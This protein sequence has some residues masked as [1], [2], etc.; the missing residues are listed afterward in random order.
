MRSRAH[1]PIAILVLLLASA[2]PTLAG[3]ATPAATWTVGLKDVDQKLRAR[4]WEAAEKQAR[5]VAVQIIEGSGTGPGASYSLA[6]ISAFRAIAAAGLG[7]EDEADW[8]WASALNLFPDIA[9]TDLA[10]YGPPAAGLK[11][12]QLRFTETDS[13]A[14]D[15]PKVIEETKARQEDVQPPKI[16]RQVRPR[17]PEGLRS[18]RVAGKVVM[19]TIIGEDGVVR[20]PRVLQTGGAGPAMAYVALDSLREWRFEPA[21]LDGKPVKVYYVLTVNFGYKG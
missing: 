4:Q 14:P 2:L 18:M 12:R 3:R 19:E 15:T 5:K 17:F 6:V 20:H 10:P 7:R 13:S 9:K 11:A 1:P 16:V 21:R 8:Y